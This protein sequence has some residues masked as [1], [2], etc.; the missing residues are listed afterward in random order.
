[1]RCELPERGEP[2]DDVDQARQ[3]A[4]VAEYRRDEIEVEQTDQ[5]P[6]DA[7]DDGQ[8]QGCEVQGFHVMPPPVV[9]DLELAADG[10]RFK[11]RRSQSCDTSP[12]HL[13]GNTQ[14]LHDD[15]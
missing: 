6:V 7:A 13:G 10:T 1:E 5:S 3:R 9:P 2:D 14:S 8:D 4:A 11:M 15:V 12:H